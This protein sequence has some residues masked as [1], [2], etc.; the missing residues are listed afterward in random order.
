MSREM[1]FIC[2]WPTDLGQDIPVDLT[3]LSLGKDER[4]IELPVSC[5]NYGLFSLLYQYSEITPRKRQNHAVTV[6][7]YYNRAKL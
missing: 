4:Y 5:S 7:T 2:L 6:R 3:S 1:V